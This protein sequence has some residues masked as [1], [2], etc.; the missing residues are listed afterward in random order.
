MSSLGVEA[1]GTASLRAAGMLRF[2]DEADP[3]SP[4]P[5]A[6]RGAEMPPPSW[7]GQG[8]QLGWDAWVLQGCGGTLKIWGTNAGSGG[9][10]C[11]GGLL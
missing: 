5:G 2:W 9:G 10:G 3:P 6:G 7:E 8:V 4:K 11:C 1:V